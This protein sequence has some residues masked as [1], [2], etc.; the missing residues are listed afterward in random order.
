MQPALV[1]AGRGGSERPAPGRIRTTKGVH[2]VCPPVTDRALVL[3]SDVDRRLL[4]AIPRAGQTWIGTTDT[5]YDGDPAEVRATRADVDYLLGSVRGLFPSLTIADVL[6]TTAG[7]RA[8]V[9][10]GGHASSVSRMH[11]W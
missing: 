10:Q 2:I 7:V 1:G 3:F 11:K 5:D 8:L 9:T 6:H 4:F